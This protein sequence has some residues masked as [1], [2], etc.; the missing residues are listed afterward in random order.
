MLT[1]AARV[2]W[3][4]M[5]WQECT[6]KSRLALELALAAGDQ[7]SELYARAWL[8]RDA[9]IRGDLTTAR[10][11]AASTLE[12]AE[13]LRERYWLATAR[14]NSF[15]IAALPGDWDAARG[16]S[17]AGLAAQP[18]DRRNLAVRGLLEHDLGDGDA[19]DALLECCSRQ[20]ARSVRTR[21]SSTRQPLRR[22][23]SPAD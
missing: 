19:G 20:C 9:A 17:D 12:L 1:L 15:W 23:H 14:L 2:D 13:R 11:H 6:E 5:R 22:S 21:Q 18:R 8:T 3:W 4:F 16:L 10:A 7:Q